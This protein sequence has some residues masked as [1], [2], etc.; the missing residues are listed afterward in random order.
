[1]RVTSRHACDRL[2]A[3]SLPALAGCRECGPRSA[4]RPA[5]DQ[6]LAVRKKGPRYHSRKEKLSTAA[7]ACDCPELRAAPSRGGLLHHLQCSSFRLC[8]VLKCFSAKSQT[9]SSNLRACLRW[10]P[11]S[12]EKIGRFGRGA[13]PH[14]QH[15]GG[16]AGEL[17]QRGG[18]AAQ[19]CPGG[20]D[21]GPPTGTGHVL[22]QAPPQKKRNFEALV[23]RHT[24]S[25]SKGFGVE[26]PKIES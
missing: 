11:F 24:Q 15:R 1:M 17:G 20:G 13:G 18:A 7:P 12:D 10:R 2:I 14:L 16:H 26:P 23:W 21:Q 8:M 4:P 3:P 6:S 19:R 25:R 22:K 9:L 5:R